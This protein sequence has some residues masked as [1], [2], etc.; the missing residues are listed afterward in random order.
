ML[1]A[2]ASAGAAGRG[3]RRAPGPGRRGVGGMRRGEERRGQRFHGDVSGRSPPASPR[4]EGARGSADTSLA[5]D[6]IIAYWGKKRAQGRGGGPSASAPPVDIPSATSPALPA[7]RRK[8][9][10]YR[11]LCAASV[12]GAAAGSMGSLRDTW[13]PLGWAFPG[14]RGAKPLRRHPAARP[15]PDGA[16]GPR[17]PRPPTSSA[18][19]ISRRLRDRPR[20]PAPGSA[21]ARS[22]PRAGGGSAGRARGIAPRAAAGS[23]QLPPRVRRSLGGRGAQNPPQPKHVPFSAQVAEMKRATGLL[24]CASGFFCRNPTCVWISSHSGP[25]RAQWKGSCVFLMPRSRQ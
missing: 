12:G 1:P 20:K 3:G 19:R 18:P 5:E 9:R 11:A 24:C 22:A 21:A 4:T 15:P 6:L 25:G 8:S 2:S 17:S 10:R 13:P 14:K 23:E 16:E 7:E